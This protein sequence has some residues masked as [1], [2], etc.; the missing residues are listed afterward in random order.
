MRVYLKDKYGVML[1]YYLIGYIEENAKLYESLVK[2][3]YRLIF[4]EVSKG[5]D[6]N[7]KGNVDAEIVLQAMIDIQTYSGAIIIS[8]DGD[9]ACL[10]R[11]LNGQ[12]KLRIV[13]A[14]SRRSCS[15]LLSK[16]AGAKIAFLADMRHKLEYIK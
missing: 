1:A 15:K 11:H 10:V 12:Q 9:F 6:D 5:Q 7:V 3:G 2:S 8:S 4:K 14:A 13:L 16:A